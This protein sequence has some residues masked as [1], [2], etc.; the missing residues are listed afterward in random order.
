MSNPGF[1]D[2]WIH[3][4]DPIR[5]EVRLRLHAVEP[6]VELRGRLL[7]PRCRFTS[8]IEIAYP[9]RPAGP[10]GEYAANVPEPSLWEPARPFL[11]EGPIE[12]LGPSGRSEE[13]RL[14]L[15]FR[16]LKLGPKGL[17]L[18]GKSIAIRGKELS[19]VPDEA[20]LLE[21]RQQGVNALLGDV[22][23][24]MGSIS[25]LADRLGF[26]VILRERPGDNGQESFCCQ[27]DGLKLP[28]ITRQPDGTFTL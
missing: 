14:M 26:L 2:V 13:G 10:P 23:V 17:T 20:E 28:G 7:G 24:Q 11:Y 5:A 12:R 1:L 15:C 25:D 16:T 3:R 19:A 21:L 6:G 18:N 9:F 22:D 8:T 4:V 27:L